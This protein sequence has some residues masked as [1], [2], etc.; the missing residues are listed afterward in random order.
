MIKISLSASF[1]CRTYKLSHL[2]Y[3]IYSETQFLKKSCVFI[4]VYQKKAVPL[5]SHLEKGSRC[6]SCTVPLL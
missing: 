3:A 5:Q 2:P 1:S 4:C 6:E